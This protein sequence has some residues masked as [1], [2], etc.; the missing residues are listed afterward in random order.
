V[1]GSRAGAAPHRAVHWFVDLWTASIVLTPLSLACS[2]FSAFVKYLDARPSGH[3][4]A[5]PKVQSMFA[6]TYRDPAA[7]AA[8]L[9][10]KCESAG[11]WLLTAGVMALLALG[12][13]VVFVYLAITTT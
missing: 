12:T 11:G 1:E 5:P 6:R 8:S 3:T 7:P 4:C 13:F 10:L 9:C 2:A